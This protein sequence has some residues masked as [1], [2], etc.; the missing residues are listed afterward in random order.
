MGAV[1]AQHGPYGQH[2][3]QTMHG[4]VEN[5]LLQAVAASR[6]DNSTYI[7]IERRAR[8]EGDG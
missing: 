3:A 2:D 7:T 8:C 4:K 6:R 5:S 1:E